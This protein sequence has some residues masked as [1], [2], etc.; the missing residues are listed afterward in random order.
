MQGRGG[1]ARRAQ[2]SSCH[3]TSSGRNTPEATRGR[4]C[5]KGTLEVPPPVPPIT[6]FHKSHFQRRPPALTES[7]E[8][9]PPPEKT[10]SSWPSS[11]RQ[12]AHCPVPGDMRAPGWPAGP[13]SPRPGRV[14][15]A[16]PRVPER[17]AGGRCVSWLRS[18]RELGGARPARTQALREGR[19][20]G[21]P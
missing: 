16:A 13:C 6:P 10:G 21:R 12:R 11:V 7:E 4:T 2:I 14:A 15:G 3:L 19:T 8:P 5:M 17:T 9:G 1:G 20:G 18:H